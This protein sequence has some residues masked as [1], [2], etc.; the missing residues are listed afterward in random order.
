M[1]F[2]TL[3]GQTPVPCDDITEWVQLI[4]AGD[5]RTVF[6]ATVD[7]YFVSTVFLGIDHNWSG[8]VPILFETMIFLR[9]EEVEEQ[10]DWE[11]VGYQ[12]RYSTWLEAEQGHEEAVKLTEQHAGTARTV[13]PMIAER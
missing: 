10:A 6:Q 5:A 3:I 13:Q 8:G 2:Y 4:E 7:G 9:R 11:L 12:R 1:R